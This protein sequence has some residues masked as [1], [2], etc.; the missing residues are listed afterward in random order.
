MYTT[1][2]IITGCNRNSKSVYE[3]YLKCTYKTTV[4]GCGKAISSVFNMFNC[5]K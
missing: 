3:A 2:S 4:F 5:L 1:I